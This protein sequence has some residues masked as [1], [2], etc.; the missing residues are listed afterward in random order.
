MWLVE[1]L[2]ALYINRLNSH[3]TAFRRR[4]INK[5]KVDSL[6]K[7]VVGQTIMK[8]LR[9]AFTQWKEQS[10]KT[11]LVAELHDEGPVRE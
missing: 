6:K 2:Q 1:T 5:A 4:C 11:T 7:V 9:Q 3:V 8:A 10:E